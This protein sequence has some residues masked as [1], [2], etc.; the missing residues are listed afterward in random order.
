[1]WLV[2]VA[3][4]V[5]VAILSALAVLRRAP[6]PAG[7]DPE[8]LR[9]VAVWRDNATI[10][11]DIAGDAHEQLRQLVGALAE[12]G[13]ILASSI[14]REG[15]R[16]ARRSLAMVD[17][18]ERRYQLRLCGWRGDRWLL[19]IDERGQAPTDSDELRQ[20]LTG[21]HRT[22]ER[23]EVERGCWHRRENIT[24]GEGAPSPFYVG[25]PG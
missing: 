8:G 7:H 14:D 1:M 17:V 9:T 20:L 10:A 18:N 5:I 13:F 16:A 22:L 21:L 6:T 23:R 24:D 12:R 19:W 3:P 15:D 4:V 11:A 25:A 2:L